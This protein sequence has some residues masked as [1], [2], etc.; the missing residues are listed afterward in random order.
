[1][2]WLYPTDWQSSPTHI[3]LV[4]CGLLTLPLFRFRGGQVILCLYKTNSVYNI[5]YSFK[6]HSVY[7]TLCQAVP[8]RLN[9]NV[10]F[11]SPSNLIQLCSV[12]IHSAFPWPYPFSHFS[13]ISNN[14]PVIFLYLH[15]RVPLNQ[16]VLNCEPQHADETCVCVHACAYVC[17]CV[18][19]EKKKK[20]CWECSWVGGV[21]TV[22]S[23]A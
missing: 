4:L 2:K 22:P 16:Y 9:L 21:D 8:S 12:V 17:V 19:K 15:S 11:L 13:V 20:R 10:F 7:T 3:P 14:T 23:T 5:L 1:M 18:F 6:T